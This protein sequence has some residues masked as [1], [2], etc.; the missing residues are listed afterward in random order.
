MSDTPE[1]EAYE[2]E[3]R[4]NNSAGWRKLAE[5]AIAENQIYRNRIQELQ[6]Q[7]ADLSEER[8]MLIRD[9]QIMREENKR[10]RRLM[11][12]AQLQSSLLRDQ[13]GA[14]DSLKGCASIHPCGTEVVVQ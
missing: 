12:S 4:A 10:M 14:P 5:Q 9:S 3:R 13:A 1:Q 2:I 7:V 6:L 11:T 8:A